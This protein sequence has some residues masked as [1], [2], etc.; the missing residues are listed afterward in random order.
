M[1]GFWRAF[2]DSILI[3]F[4]WSGILWEFLRPGGAV[5]GAAGGV[6][7]LLGLSRMLPERPWLAT[8]VSAP[9]I[10]LSGWLLSIAWRARKNKRSVQ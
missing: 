5:P 1:S 7:L 6:L 8:A 2:T 10:V 9:F 4:G 3:A